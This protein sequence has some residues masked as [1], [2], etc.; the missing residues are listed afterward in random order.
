MKEATKM[1]NNE[2]WR[3]SIDEEMDAL[4]KNEHG[5]WYYFLMDGNSL[6]ANG[7]SRKISI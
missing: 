1:E 6:D 7:P 2:S 5:T 4:R 3:I